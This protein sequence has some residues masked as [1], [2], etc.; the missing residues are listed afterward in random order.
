MVA[1]KDTKPAA[2]AADMMK[3]DAQIFQ[4]P[5][6]EVPEAVREAAEKGVA[7][8]KDAYEKLKVA[9]EETTELVEDTYS[10]YTK[11]A[12]EISGKVLDFTKLNT[13]VAFDFAKDL[14]AVRSVAELVEKQTAFAR[15]QFEALTGQSKEIQSLAQAISTDIQAPVKAAAEKAISQFKKS[16]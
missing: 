7:Q 14:L 5:K 6:M 4:L 11:G 15:S 8:A 13:T 12:A 16:A 10:T 1:K 9:A 3:F 2:A